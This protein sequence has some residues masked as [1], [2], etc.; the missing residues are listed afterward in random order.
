MNA[1]FDLVRFPGW[2]PKT[3]PLLFLIV[4]AV[5]A[6]CGKQN[7]SAP[8]AAPP[9]TPVA[10]APAVPTQTQT[11]PAPRANPPPMT[12]TNSSGLTTLQFL[13][14]AMVRWMRTNHRHPQSFEDFASTAN[15]QIPAP[16]S[17]KKYT[18]NGRGFIV[19]VDIST[20]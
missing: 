20:Q 9:E 4:G 15:I 12:T 7:T 11:T 18:L 17:G 8:A 16:P 3:M 2:R 10:A 6:G 1:L 19:L 13:N 5:A 14:R